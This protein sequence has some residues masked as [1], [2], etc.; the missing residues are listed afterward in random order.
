MESLIYLL[1]L[2]AVGFCFFLM[3]R[4]GIYP[5]AIVTVTFPDGNKIT[6]TEMELQKLS[7]SWEEAFAHLKPTSRTKVSFQ[8][9]YIE[10]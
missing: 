9:T 5:I 4:A 10:N 7:K 8:A 6:F 3:K 1:C 2:I